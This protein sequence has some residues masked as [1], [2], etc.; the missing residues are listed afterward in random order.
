MHV[1]V[2]LTVT[3]LDSHTLLVVA[4]FSLSHRRADLCI[5]RHLYTVAIHA[6]VKRE[7]AKRVSQWCGVWL[8]VRSDN[9]VCVS[10]SGVVASVGVAQ[11]A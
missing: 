7:V 2:C 10:A 1:R 8:N 3:L 4:R 6:L 5:W 9:F 11:R